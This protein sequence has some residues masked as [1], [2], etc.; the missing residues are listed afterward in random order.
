[1]VKYA[2][3]NKSVSVIFIST[4]VIFILL[5]VLF[6]WDYLTNISYQLNGFF[7]VLIT[8]GIIIIPVEAI[9]WFI[10]WIRYHANK[11]NSIVCNRILNI[12]AVLSFVTCAAVM[13]FYANEMTSGGYANDIEKYSINKEYF[14]KFD[15]KLIEISQEQYNKLENGKWYHFEYK[16]N[17]L[18]SDDYRITLLE[19]EE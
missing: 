9:V 4:C 13:T 8:A 10:V 3:Y 14:I 6:E 1:M 12:V 15:N 5:L 16:Y 7:A 18:I 19:E 17:N 11:S 2:R